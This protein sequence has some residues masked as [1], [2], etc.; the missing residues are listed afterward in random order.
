MYPHSLSYQLNTYEKPST[1]TNKSWQHLLMWCLKTH[2]FTEFMLPGA[3]LERHQCLSKE[4]DN[5]FLQHTTD[6]CSE[7]S[8]TEADCN[9]SHLVFLCFRRAVKF[10][11][12][13]TR[14]SV[15]QTVI[16]LCVC[17]NTY[18]QKGT[19]VLFLQWILLKC[20][21]STTQWIKIFMMYQY[22][23]LVK[24]FTNT[25]FNIPVIVYASRQTDYWA[26]HIGISFMAGRMSIRLL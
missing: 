1:I 19:T 11:V 3:V 25:F 8:H 5:Y 14:L 15:Y 7:H 26:I 17:P 4:E 9:F 18:Q 2:K 6:S 16:S 23:T 10:M 13:L 20:Q 24:M 22:V 12:Y 21:N